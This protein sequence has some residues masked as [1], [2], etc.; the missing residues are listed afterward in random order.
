MAWT[1]VGNIKGPQGDPGA[2]GADSTVPGPQGDPGADGADS[3]VPGPTGPTGATG[4][5]GAASTVP[6]PQGIQG[7]TGATGA[8]GTPGSTDAVSEGS[9]N[10]YYTN[11][12]ADARVVAAGVTAATASTIA[13]RDSNAN[14]TADGYISSATNTASS[15]GTLT[16]TIADTQ[17][18]VIT[19]STTHT[20]ALPTTSVTRGMWYIIVNQ[21]SGTVTV[22]SSG[23][24]FVG[25]LFGT[26]QGGGVGIYFAVV[27]TPTTAA[28]WQGFSPSNIGG[29]G[30]IAMRNA[31]GNI[32]ADAF[33]PK[34]TATATSAG[35]LTMD[36]NSIQTQVFTG[37]TTHT[38]KLPTTSVLAGYTY[39]VVNNSSGN[40]TVQSSGANTIA[41]VAGGSSGVFLAQVDTPTTAA[42]WKVVFNA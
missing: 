23:G 15:A 10:L 14:M 5:T 21:S 4:A 30:T 9:T 8:A 16:M 28:N 20:V 24:N 27:D 31:N 37:S 29:I 3:T 6:G 25:Q 19:G 1:L 32:V 42:N 36:I 40:V 26:G 22:N 17:V 33:L 39:N 34:N 41:T 7:A 38:V 12:R 11:A 18:Q 13:Q 35:T 2:D